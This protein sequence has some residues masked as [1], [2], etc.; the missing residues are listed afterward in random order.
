MAKQRTYKVWKKGERLTTET[1]I[2][3]S[4]GR[5]RA[6]LSYAAAQGIKTIDCDAIWVKE[7]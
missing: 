6:L 3:T 5:F 4:E 7:K 2:T 1:E